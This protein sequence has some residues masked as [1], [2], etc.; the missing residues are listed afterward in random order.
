MKQQRSRKYKML[1]NQCLW[2]D[3]IKPIFKRQM[4]TIS[5]DFI[6]RRSCTIAIYHGNKCDPISFQY[7]S[8]ICL[9]TMFTCLS[10][11]SAN[12]RKSIDIITNTEQKYIWF[13]QEIVDEKSKI[14]LNCL[15]SFIFMISSLDAQSKNKSK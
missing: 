2:Q 13:S 4:Y 6:Y 14:I 8:I 7:L 5:V 11:R 3:N 15:H 9:N 1:W 12:R 10:I